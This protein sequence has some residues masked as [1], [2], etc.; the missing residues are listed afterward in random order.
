MCLCF[1]FQGLSSAQ[2]QFIWWNFTFSNTR[3]QA[4]LLAGYELSKDKSCIW[5]VH[6]HTASTQ[7]YVGQS[8]YTVSPDWTNKPMFSFGDIP[9]PDL[10]GWVMAASFPDLKWLTIW[11]NRHGPAATAG[12]H[13]VEN[14]KANKVQLSNLSSD[15]LTAAMFNYGKQMTVS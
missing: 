13:Q 10:V 1:K 2:G 5:L 3:K 11:S 15:G 4:C 7:H 9:M 12:S 8:R 6:Q 14:R